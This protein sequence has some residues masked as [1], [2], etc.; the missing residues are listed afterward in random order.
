MEMRS[1][2][3]EVFV[4]IKQIICTTPVLAYCIQQKELSIQYDGN[5]VQYFHR[6]ETNRFLEQDS[7]NLWNKICPK[8]DLKNLISEIRRIKKPAN[9]F[10]HAIRLKTPTF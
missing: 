3:E 7:N 4:E 6:T 1:A 2:S 5:Q 9:I 10:W 8:V